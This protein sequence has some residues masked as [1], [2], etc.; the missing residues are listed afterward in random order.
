MLLFTYV[1]L[2]STVLVEE[3]SN[4]LNDSNPIAIFLSVSVFKSKA[5]A[6]KAILLLPFVVAFI[7]LAPNITFPPPAFKLT[8]HWYPIIILLSPSNVPREAHPV[9]I[10]T[11]LLQLSVIFCAQL[12][13]IATL[14]SELL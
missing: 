5:C 8:P 3:F 2:P 10:K 14:L 9:P 13:P 4:F 1:P 11:F 12:Y 7:H 6:P